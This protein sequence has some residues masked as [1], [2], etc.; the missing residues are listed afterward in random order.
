MKLIF[1]YDQQPTEHVEQIQTQLDLPIE[2][3]RDNL[4]LPN[5]NETDIVRHYTNLSKKNFGID[6]NLYP[7]GSCT[8]KY[9]PKV[10][11]ELARLKGF[12][13]IHPH[14]PAEYSQ[15]S[16]EVIWEL[17]EALKEITG[18]DDISLQPAAG[19]QCELLGIMMAKR[20]FENKNE[21][22]AKVIIPDS[23]HG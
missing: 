22:R 5:V 6:N 8:M 14:S 17:Q 1:E 10:S 16:L 7:L 18:M 4:P 13:S 9:N 23:S 3:I 20:H 11:E 19:S 21:K 2:L 12:A 15:G